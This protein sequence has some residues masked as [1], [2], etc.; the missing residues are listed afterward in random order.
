M[1]TAL[2]APGSDDLLVV[3][4]LSA[5]LFRAY[6][7]IRPLSSPTGEPTH[8]VYG[9]VTILERLVKDMRPKRLAIALDSGRQTFRSNLYPEYK[10]NRPEPP[11][12]LLI[13]LRRAS[14]VVR[15]FTPHVWQK[16]G[17]EADDL[18][19]T[20][21]RRARL[22]GLRTLIVGADKDLMQLVGSDVQ[23][24]DTMRDRVIGPEEVFEKFAVRVDQL[25]DLL[26]LMGDSSDNIPGVAGIGPKTAAEL[27]TAYGTLDGIYAHLADL[28]RKRIG[29]LLMEHEAMARLSRQLVTLA[30][31]CDP[32][33]DPNR[34][35]W[36]GRDVGRLRA[37]YAELGFTRLAQALSVEIDATGAAQSVRALPNGTAAS[38]ELSAATADGPTAAVV[39]PS[40]GQGAFDFARVAERP[41]VLDSLAALANWLDAE[42]DTRTSAI[43]LRRA[44]DHA[45]R[46]AWFALGI[47]TNETRSAAV[48][49]AHEIEGAAAA[50]QT[51]IPVKALCAL[52][53]DHFRRE[54]HEIQTHG[55]K[56]LWLALLDMDLTDVNIGFDTELASYLLDPEQMLT[57]PALNQRYLGNQASH[58]I[59]TPSRRNAEPVSDSQLFADTAERARIIYRLCR[60]MAPRIADEGLER[61]YYDIELPLCRVL[62]RMQRVGVL[63]D[64]SHLAAMSL[65]LDREIARLENEATETAGHPF[66]L[67]SPRQLEGILFDE[68]GLKPIRRT[69]TSRST[70]AATLEAL[71]EEH[72]LPR[73]ILA[74]RQVAK[75]K[76]TYVDA[77]PALVDR[78]TGR[79]HSSWEQ[80]VAATGRLSSTDPNLQNIPVRTELGRAIRRAF[81][82]PEG[83]QIVSADYSQ[84]ELRVLAHLSRDPELLLAFQS[85]TDVHLRTAA[86]VFDVDVGAVTKEMRR[87]A[88]AVNFGVIYGQTE[89][90]LASA[91]GISRHQASEFIAAYYRRYRGVREFMNRT[92]EQARHG[93]AVRSL[94]GRRRY[95]NEIDSA[96]RSLRLAAERMAMNMPIQATAADLLKMAMLKLDE[97]VTPGARMIMSVHD[98]LVFEIPHDEVALAKTRIADTM[99]EVADLS[100]KLL[101][102]VGHG[103]N[104][105]D[106]H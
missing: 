26:A 91:L 17:Y 94:F 27:L 51:G 80:V 105:A 79:V 74:H 24:W 29:T 43:S 88:K 9:V 14:E 46:S 75:L 6:H 102:E 20:A 90:G 65:E 87:Q 13:Q 106:A 78:A 103:S 53:R 44:D 55:A 98:E 34:T 15:A 73:L 68:L 11:E 66:N 12:D 18:I 45:T 81:V 82:A 92:I 42:H 33:I 71:A 64:T 31:D 49:I 89:S 56:A 5:Q 104:W 58:L 1:P 47:A 39:T 85:N 101:V 63:V 69:K 32:D 61:I 3:V 96:N 10:A 72:P 21:V 40:Q 52:L 8:A 77:L 7:A 41:L 84:I 50:S 97:P 28:P 19:A 35:T 16:A 93:K 4:D 59:A 54:G 70:D 23:L 48:P 36:T 95:F 62:A 76:S 37:L 86:A 30:D 100:V 22:A 67:N 2:F 99:Q 57:L 38:D 83:H 60:V 25:G